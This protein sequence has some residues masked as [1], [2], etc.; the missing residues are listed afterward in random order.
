MLSEYLGSI[1]DNADTI[2]Q[3]SIVFYTIVL[4]C[5]I[6]FIMNNVSDVSFTV[7]FAICMQ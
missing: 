1:P 6:I 5:F 2:S 4:I 3:G 7:S